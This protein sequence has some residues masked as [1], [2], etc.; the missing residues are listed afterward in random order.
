M[1]RTVS[2]PDVCFRAWASAGEARVPNYE[3]SNK[4]NIYYHVPGN[5]LSLPSFLLS[6]FYGGGRIPCEAARLCTGKWAPAW[7]QSCH[8]ASLGQDTFS[9]WASVSSSLKWGFVSLMSQWGTLQMSQGTSGLLE[10]VCT[11]ICTHFFPV[12]WSVASHFLAWSKP[13]WGYIY[14]IEICKFYKAALPPPPNQAVKGLLAHHCYCQSQG[15][16]P[17]YFNRKQTL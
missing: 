3:D 7:F 6:S 4:T 5:K 13:L 12:P 16:F 1:W 9:L 11:S 2:L 8:K 14:T 10:L 17:L 15:D